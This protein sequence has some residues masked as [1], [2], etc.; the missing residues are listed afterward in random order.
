MTNDEGAAQVTSLRRTF[1]PGTND[2]GA[3]VRC[4]HQIGD[5]RNCRTN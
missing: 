1:S 3:L 4:T 5:P 2:E